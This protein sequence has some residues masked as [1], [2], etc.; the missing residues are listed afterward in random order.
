MPDLPFA[1]IDL[2]TRPADLIAHC[3][4][5]HAVGPVPHTAGGSA[6]G[7]ARWEK[8]RAAGLPH[9]ARRRNDPL[10]EGTSRLS[11][12]LHYGMVSPLRI[13]REAAAAAV[14]GSDKYLDELL[15]WREMAYAFCRYRPDHETLAALPDWAR[16]TLRRH[17]SDPRPARYSWET[18]ARGRTGDPLWDAAQR[19]L[20]IHGELH[21]N[22]RMTWGKALLNWTRDAESALRVIID[23][24]HRYALDGSDPASFGGILWCLGQ[25]DRPF[26][27]PQPI[28][29][30][31]RG[32]STQEHARRLDVEAYTRRATRPLHSPAPRIAVVGAGVS[33][34]ICARTLSDHG[35]RVT[36]FE[37]SRGVGGRMATRRTAEG[38][39]FDHGAQYFTVRDPRFQR[40]VDAWTHD[41]IAAPWAGR[42]GSA[43]RGRLESKSGKTQRFVGVPSMN[44]VC[45][46]LAGDMTIQF[47]TPVNSLARTDGIWT[48]RDDAG[49]VLGEFDGLVC[50]VPGPQCAQLLAALPE[51]R[52]PCAAVPMASCWAVMLAF[53]EA[54]ELSLDG[55]FIAE[56]PLSWAARNCSKPGRSVD[57]E[58]R[59]DTWILHATPEW[60]DAHLEADAATVWPALLEAFWQATGLPKRPPSYAAC[61][62]WRY[63]LPLEPL[64]S[65]CLFDPDLL[66]GACGDWCCG[67][68][69]EGAFLSGQTL[70]GRLLSQLAAVGQADLAI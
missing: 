32:R 23:L 47:R 63:A 16:D 10:L 33:G 69:V 52:Q 58:E 61:H 2:A 17:A 62:R 21:N 3:D 39:S 60:T 70:A 26:P 22:V 41:G 30:T 42:L 9:Y 40:Y 64:E 7:Y 25:F 24:N 57:P 29:G 19:S 53:A 35:L 43:C 13:A 67:P 20:L 11:P 46:H 45:R 48:L 8:F 66:V 37:K 4:I 38:P 31:V 15:V 1:P 34:L 51:M 28:R 5:D 65:R 54:L 49:R 14:A 50:A 68:R 6:A 44:A 55:L 59:P 36:V 12:Y 56:S 27:P 18:L